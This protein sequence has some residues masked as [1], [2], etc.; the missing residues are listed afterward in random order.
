VTDEASAVGTHTVAALPGGTVTV[1]V[2]RQPVRGKFWRF[3][4]GRGGDAHL[5]LPS[6]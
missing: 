5:S 4:V 3:L 2:T 6:G 1:S